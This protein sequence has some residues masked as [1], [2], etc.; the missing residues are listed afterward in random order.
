MNNRAKE[1]QET[2]HE[3]VGI[4]GKKARINKATAK[5]LPQWHCTYLDPDHSSS[6]VIK[7]HRSCISER[8]NEKACTCINIIVRTQTTRDTSTEATQQDNLGTYK[9]CGFAGTIFETNRI[10]YRST[11]LILFCQGSTCFCY[12]GGD[13]IG[14]TLGNGHGSYTT[15][16]RTAHN[17]VLAISFFQEVLGQLGRLWE[18]KKEIEN[19]RNCLTSI[20]L[21]AVEDIVSPS[22]RGERTFM[23]LWM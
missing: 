11:Q 18:R 7:H 17:A 21:S 8:V 23:C 2:N 16:L 13:F 22:R 12:T 14:N 10:S 1:K 4:V 15:W 6:L 9:F 3:N 20:V 19:M 5:C